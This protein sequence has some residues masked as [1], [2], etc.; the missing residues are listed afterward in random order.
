MVQL[1]AETLAEL[2][3]ALIDMRDYTL[4]CGSAT[5]PQPSDEQV[6]IQWVDDDKDFNVG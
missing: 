3:Q 5:H 6:L 4:V 2:K 1:S